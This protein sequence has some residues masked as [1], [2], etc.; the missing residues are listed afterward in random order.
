VL[1]V[2]DS[3]AHRRIIASQ[4]LRA[5]HRVIEAASGEAALAA[6]RHARPDVVIS[7]WMMPGMSGLDLCREL[8]AADLGRYVYFILLTSRSEKDDIAL[9]LR[10]GADDFLR[11]PVSGDELRARI[12]A[13][14]RILRMERELTHKNRLLSRT[15]DELRSLH[16]SI[17]R[18]LIEARHLQQSLVRDTFRSFG[19]SQL[20][21]ILRPSGHVGGDLVGYFPINARRV[22]VFAIDVSGHGIAS[23]FMTARIA[24]YLSGASPEHN[25][26]LVLNELGIYDAH[27]PAEVAAA[28]NR[29]VL[30]DMRG[31]S[32]LTLAYADIDLVSG[33]ASV[34]QA[35]HPHPVV[36]R[37]SGRVEFHGAGGL[38]VG[39]FPDAMFE[40]FDVTLG[41]GDSLFLMSDGVIEAEDAQ[42]DLLGE[43]GLAAMLRMRAALSG[44]AKLEALVG[45][46]ARRSDKA[47]S[48][49][50]SGALFEF[51]RAK[52]NAD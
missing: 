27:P 3:R 26:A 9:G 28:L 23:A 1:V 2:D 6:C 17:N 49:D 18:D 19:S 48:D 22:G 7:D 45:D 31:E 5:G 51:S 24:G 12:A 14:A 42:G 11:K 30:R 25:V 16:D 21:L 10:I 34:V 15:I 46:L 50:I 20:S 13:G 40:Q 8:R 37:A 47:P 44:P 4:L 33:V 32:Y 43:D 39:L 36:M 52:A 35:G 29:I 38:P 41:P